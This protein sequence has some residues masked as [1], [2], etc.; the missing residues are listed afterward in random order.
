[1]NSAVTVCRPPV[2]NRI[3]KLH[4]STFGYLQHDSQS[5]WIGCHH[6]E[7]YLE[8]VLYGSSHSQPVDIFPF[9]RNYTRQSQEA[10]SCDSTSQSCQIPCRRN[11][12]RQYQEAVSCYNTSQSCQI[13]CHHT[14]R[15]LETAPASGSH[16]Q[17]MDI[18][19]F[20]KN[21]TRQRCAKIDAA[22]VCC[23][24]FSLLFVK[25]HYFVLK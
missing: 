23:L 2:P 15:S 13:P 25:C 7:W 19:L 21:Y 18:F 16:S 5:C 1:M 17:P 8:T 24:Q 4:L 12:T 22:A 10:V 6:A 3:L 11:Y 9:H 14:E 20:H